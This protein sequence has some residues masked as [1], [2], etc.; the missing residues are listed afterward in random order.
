MSYYDQYKNATFAPDYQTPDWYRQNFGIGI[1]GN[2]ASMDAYFATHPAEAADF[3]R[4]TSGQTSQMSTNGSTLLK[5]PF[6]NMSQDAQGYYSQNPNAQLAAEG[7]G[8]D[9]TLAYMNYTQGPGSIGIKDPKNTNSTSYMRD[10]RWTPNGI[11]GNNNSAMYAAMPFGGG[12]SKRGEH[13]QHP[14][15]SG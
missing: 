8:M 6:A 13:L 11:Q 3:Q 7:F 1:D 5:T 4:I 12:W 9:P 2:G 14:P 15:P 10:N